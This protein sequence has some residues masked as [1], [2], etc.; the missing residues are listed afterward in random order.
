ML[1]GD[2]HAQM[3]RE[4][5]MSTARKA[6]FTGIV[7]TE[8]GCPWMDIPALSD[9]TGEL[10]RCQETL[11]KPVLAAARKYKPDVVILASRSVLSR[12]LLQGGQVI[13]GG[14][15]GWEELVRSGVT[16][17]LDKITKVAG[18]VVLLEPYPMTSKPMIRCLSTDAKPSTCDLPATFL[19]G[20]PYVEDLYA[21]QSDRYEN[22]TSL[23]LDD[24]ICPGG[25]CRAMVDGV[26]TF[27]DDNHLT[28][29]YAASLM[30][31][32]LRELAKSGITVRGT[33]GR[34]VVKGGSP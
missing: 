3:W 17:S 27:A 16:S 1:V 2:S 21:Q 7:I 32:L 14:D 13:T 23:N 19:P 26:V 11:L 4:G 28:V 5:F 34:P 33:G 8:S 6:G 29:D 18:T 31:D 15:P 30:P 9:R 25:T 20:T 22:V 12:R 10:H 24:V